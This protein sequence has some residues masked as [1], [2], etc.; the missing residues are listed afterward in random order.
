MERYTLGILVNNQPGVLSRVVGLFSRRGYNIDSLSVGETEDPKISRI[1]IVVTGD[2][3][4][5][6]QIEKQV[7]KLIDVITVVELTL[8]GSIQCELLLVKV[9]TSEKTR[10]AVVE[11]SEIFKAKIMDVTETTLTMQITGNMDKVASF[12]HL[13]RPYGITELVRTGMTAMERGSQAMV[14]HRDED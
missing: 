12:L 7:A 11:L 3:P 2:R 4:I 8:Q 9:T 6:E 10:A 5:V 13:L 14:N 1:T